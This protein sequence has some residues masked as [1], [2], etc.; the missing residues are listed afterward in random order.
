M[1]GFLFRKKGLKSEKIPKALAYFFPNNALSNDCFVRK[2]R[3]T[4]IRRHFVT[5]LHILHEVGYVAYLKMPLKICVGI[6]GL[7]FEAHFGDQS[8]DSY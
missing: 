5:I 7:R 8:F 6:C 1:C 3:K 4:N 2:N